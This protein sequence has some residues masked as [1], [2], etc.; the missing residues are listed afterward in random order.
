MDGL[1]LLAIA[2]FVAWLLAPV[3]ERRSNL[4]GYDQYYHMAHLD[5]LADQFAA[6]HLPTLSPMGG[7]TRFFLNTSGGYPT[8]LYFFNLPIR[9]LTGD[10]TATYLVSLFLI[11]LAAAGGFYLGFKARFGRLP[12]LVGSVVAVAGP[13]Q[14]TSVVPQGRWPGLQAMAFLPAFT[15]S[16]ISFL[17]APTRLRFGLIAITFGLAF[18]SHPMVAY[19]GGLGVAV[20]ALIWSVW[21]GT[22]G[23]RFLAALGAAVIGLMVLWLLVPSGLITDVLL[24]GAAGE[25]LGAPA[26]FFEESTG[27]AS[28]VDPAAAERSPYAIGFWSFSTSYRG[29]FENYAG[30][31]PLWLSI[32]VPVL[33]PRPRVIATAGAIGVLYLIAAGNDGRLFAALPFANSL[34]PRRF[35][36]VVY[37]FQGILLADALSVWIPA[38]RLAITGSPSRLWA[39][40][41]AGLRRAIHRPGNASPLRGRVAVVAIALPALAF[42]AVLW[43][44]DLLPMRETLYSYPARAIV[45]AGELRSE[46]PAIRTLA[47]DGRYLAQ[48]KTDYAE[49]YFASGAA[50]LPS[51][52]NTDAWHAAALMNVRVVDTDLGRRPE[53]V[54]EF[55]ELGFK[56]VRRSAGG[57]TVLMHSDRPT[58]YLQQPSVRVLHV[59]SGTGPTGFRALGTAGDAS[60]LDPELLRAFDVVVLSGYVA[61]DQVRARTTLDGFMLQGGIVVVDEP[62]ID[63]PDLWGALPLEGQAPRRLRFDGPSGAQSIV[64]LPEP[65]DGG[66]IDPGFG[67][68]GLAALD[69]DGGGPVDLIRE[70]AVGAGLLVRT[71]CSLGS[72]L[73]GQEAA[74]LRDAVLTYFTS[75]AG[76]ETVWPEPFPAE[77]TT[78]DHEAVSFAYSSPEPSAVVVSK[79]YDS[80]WRMTVDGHDVNVVPYAGGVML[81]PLPAGSHSVELTYLA[82]P[83]PLAGVLTALLGAGAFAVALGPMWPLTTGFGR[84]VPELVSAVMTWLFRR[85]PDPGDPAYTQPV[86]APIQIAVGQPRQV[87][88]LEFDGV[89]VDGGLHRFHLQPRASG[90]GLTVVPVTVSNVSDAPQRVEFSRRTASA[91][92]LGGQRVAARDTVRGSV[93]ASD[94]APGTGDRFVPLWGR[95]VLEPGTFVQGELVFEL[96]PGYGAL[97]VSLAPS[98]SM[99]KQAGAA[100]FRFGMAA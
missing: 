11:F 98:P 34:E 44:R 2:V 27:R 37:L 70:E 84:S 6:G 80:R 76:T 56:E 35:L 72:Q 43:Y 53:E 75:Q 46:V 16:C 36:H 79:T 85:R 61:S 4:P 55:R 60:L 74:P 59:G 47:G 22:P 65:A 1:A 42:L 51:L 54:Q 9:M 28:A 68:P 17:D 82:S 30:F 95:M 96:P 93:P 92:A 10:A 21:V 40:S 12:A 15:A 23:R 100:R 86:S 97:E 57:F 63:G 78:F 38:L 91:A 19:V 67:V 8:A 83:F 62:R 64:P 33:L 24:P 48:G 29:G 50:G 94:R 14:L 77:I 49:F 87:S 13:Y 69:A 25:V 52:I 71:C 73:S 18:V 26:G 7:G 45:S 41:L 81:A 90:A 58:A 5:F 89:A 39:A 88:R 99:A 66:L 3:Y 31:A 20:F 32:V